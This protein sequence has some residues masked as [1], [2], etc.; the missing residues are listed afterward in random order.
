MEEDRLR[1]LMPSEVITSKIDQI[2]EAFVTYYGEDRRQEI[3]NRL[4]KILIL[5]F[6]STSGLSQLINKVPENLFRE[7]YK[8]PKYESVFFNAD[9]LLNFLKSDGKDIYFFISNSTKKI[10]TGNESITNGEFYRNYH[11]G[12][13]PQ[14][15]EFIQRYETIRGKL[16][17]YIEQHNRE[18]DNESK[19]EKKYYKQ[20][21]V[22]YKYLF[23]EEEID[24]YKKY[25][26]SGGKIRAL[27]GYSINNN[28]NC[29]D[30][31]SE[32]LL[33]DPKASDWRVRSI[34]EDR[35]ELIHLMYDPD[36]EY[37]NK[38]TYE[39]YL[40][41]PKCVEFMKKLRILA[42]QISKREKELYKKMNLEIVESLEDYKNN[43][44]KIDKM[45][46]INKDDPLGPFVYNSPVSCFQENFI[47]TPNGP[48]LYP[49][50]LINSNMSELDLTIIHELNHALEYHTIEVNEKG[51]H[52]ITGWDEAYQ[53]FKNKRDNS[54]MQYKGITRKY[55]LLSEYINDRIA[56]EITTIMHSKGEYIFNK[57]ENK[58]SSS[59]KI[60]KLLVED[61][62][63]TYKNTIIKSRSHGNT[64]LIFE[65]VGRENFEALN[66]LV[67]E[68]YNTFGF[69]FSAL[70]VIKDYKDNV[71][72]EKT[73][74]LEDMLRRKN[75][76]LIKMKEHSQKR[77]I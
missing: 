77:T 22:E 41:D 2:I 60:I 39:E 50:I 76:I 3:T 61:F 28:G 42:E 37:I 19:I 36:K 59:Y 67:M 65:E 40:E 33:N 71:K 16:E 55:E 17:P 12:K 13:Y 73:A 54:D 18:K 44:T 21:I 58:S 70:N 43:R 29:F 23:S 34:K 45:N 9:D 38:P 6:V 8:L 5:K 7:I 51:V 24:N 49:L 56:E 30:N 46:Y 11:N 4:K 69:E 20:L 25:E 74:K 75:E 35:A 52:S 53:E 31:Q 66:D 57:N 68:F 72:N 15:E 27:L 63:Q 10:I 26:L 47:M 64:N 1:Y 62:F 32:K 48:V 14:L